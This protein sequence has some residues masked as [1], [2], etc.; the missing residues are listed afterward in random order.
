M[1]TKTKKR[2]E[3]RLKRW[4]SKP[5]MEIRKR[6]QR[7][8]VEDIRFL[9]KKQ[10]TKNHYRFEVAGSTGNIYS[11]D[12]TNLPSCSCP[13][14]QKR[15]DVCK[16]MLFVLMEIIG[17][18][19]DDELLYQKAF[20]TEE[21]AH[22][23]QSMNEYDDD[24]RAIRGLI[25]KLS[26]TNMEDGGYRYKNIREFTGQ[27]SIRDTSTYRCSKYNGYPY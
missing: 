11:V 3:K 23:F 16:H 25:S 6:I 17:L 8:K 26:K 18:A 20:L 9:T 21:L 7:N 19:G 10:I 27:P 24:D 15:E 2:G 14:H 5:T 1:P 22:M 12:I 13:D 4:R